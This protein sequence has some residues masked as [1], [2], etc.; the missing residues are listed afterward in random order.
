[1]RDALHEELATMGQRH[2]WYRARR[3]IVRVVLATYLPPNPDRRV[4]EVGA[5][6]GS[7]TTILSEFGTVTAVEPHSG[8]LEAC[9]SAA[10]SAEVFQGDIESL[11]TLPAVTRAPFDLVAAFDVIEHIQDDVD[12]LRRLRPLIAEGGRLVVTVPAL[13]ML[14]GAH[15]DVNGHFRRYSRAQLIRHLRLAGYETEFIS[16]FSTLLFPV[17]VAVRLSRRFFAE[18]HPEPH[19]DFRLGPKPINDLLTWCFSL[20][21]KIVRGH[22]LP[23]GSSLVAVAR[24]V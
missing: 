17:V 24:V 4:L 18:P 2:W 6:T 11:E 16:Y 12:A 9:R 21:A 19:S 14:W 20:E 13:E 10:P 22:R 1:M 3:L 23:I 8:A 7:V 5:G 15:D